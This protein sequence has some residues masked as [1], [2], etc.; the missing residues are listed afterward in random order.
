M[1]KR[2]KSHSPQSVS[3]DRYQILKMVRDPGIR[4][5]DDPML[6][7]S[8]ITA[9][10]QPDN[11]LAQEHFVRRVERQVWKRAINPDPF[12]IASPPLTS[13]YSFDIYNMH[14]ADGRPFGLTLDS[15]FRTT[16]LVGHHGAGKSTKLLLLLAQLCLMA[17]V[18]VFDRKRELRNLAGVKGLSRRWLVLHWT[19]LRIALLQSP[20]GVPLD[21][22]FTEIVS[23]V[24]RNYSLHASSR[25]LLELLHRAHAVDGDKAN[26]SSWIQQL[27][28][29]QPGKGFREAGYRESALAVL[30]SLHR[31][32]GVFDYAKSNCLELM[33]G[34]ARGIVIEVDNLPTDHYSFFVSFLIRA[35]YLSRLHST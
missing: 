34:Q 22:W 35:L 6:M 19:D 31:C 29:W 1:T 2:N 32:R 14:L 3:L 21:A 4:A 30:T 33:F 16:A 24:A 25:P 9:I 26:L 17:C 28:N 5:A 7:R 10:R 15:M 13:S 12:Y 20:S 11:S 18:I 27:R 23:L 8:A